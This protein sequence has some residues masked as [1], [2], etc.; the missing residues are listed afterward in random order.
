MYF[1]QVIA[2]NR[3]TNMTFA[4]SLKISNSRYI[5]NHRLIIEFFNLFYIILKSSTT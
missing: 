4:N 5:I 3:I 2:Q 1:K